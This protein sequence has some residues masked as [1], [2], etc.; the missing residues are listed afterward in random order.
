[1]K[2]YLLTFASFLYFFTAGA[3]SKTISFEVNGLKVI[4]KPVQKETMSMSMYFRG[5]VMNYGPEQAGIENLAL[6]AAALCGTKNYS[7]DD[8]QELADEYGIG[9]NGTSSVDYGLISMN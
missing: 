4:L 6:S 2:R 3:Q 1:M 9:I 7:V 8:Y 5:G